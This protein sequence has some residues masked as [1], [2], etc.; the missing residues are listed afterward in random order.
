MK[1]ILYPLLHKKLNFVLTLFFIFYTLVSYSQTQWNADAVGG[2]SDWNTASNWTNGVPSTSVSVTIFSCTTCPTIS[3]ANQTSGYLQVFDG[4]KL[5]ID[6]GGSLTIET[7]G[8]SAMKIWNNA[9]VTI[10]SDAELT[11]QNFYGEGISIYGSL[12]NSGFLEIDGGH[13]GIYTLESGNISN[14]SSGEINITGDFINYGIFTNSDISNDGKIIIDKA[15]QAGLY[16]Q[17]G[18]VTNN[19][20][21]T[22]SNTGVNAIFQKNKIVNAGQIN[23]IDAL[24]GLYSLSANFENTENGFLNISANSFLNKGF[25]ANNG[26]FTNHGF[27]N[28][29]NAQNTAINTSNTL[30]FDNHGEITIEYNGLYGVLNTGNSNFI[31]HPCARIYSSDKIVNW[32]NF[33]NNGLLIIQTSET[34]NIDSNNGVIYNLDGGSVS[35]ANGNI[36]LTD[37]NRHAW[38]GCKNTAWTEAENWAFGNIPMFT[39]PNH[40]EE[41][42]IPDVSMTT[43]NSPIVSNIVPS[44]AGVTMME[45][46]KLTVANGGKLSCI[47]D[48]PPEGFFKMEPNTELNIALSGELLAHE[49]RLDGE[50]T[51]GGKIQITQIINGGGN[52][53]NKGNL[54]NFGTIKGGTAGNNGSLV[55][56][57]G[58]ME[59]EGTIDIPVA[60]FGGLSNT[61]QL[62]NNNVITIMG[63]LGVGGTLFNSNGGTFQ[64][65]GQIT[66]T[67]W[68]RNIGNSTFLNT[69][70]INIYFEGTA[71]N[72]NSSTFSNSGN[73]NI[74]KGKILNENA[75]FDNSG[76]LDLATPQFG[77]ENKGNFLN[78]GNIGI[79]A[80]ELVGIVNEVNATFNNSP[81]GFISV[82]DPGLEGIANQFI[83]SNAGT[84]ELDE[85]P[86]T[87]FFVGTLGQ[88]TNLASG[89]IDITNGLNGIFLDG[90][91]NNYGQLNIG[92]SANRGMYIRDGVFQNYTGGNTTIENVGIYGI[93]LFGDMTNT[94]MLKIDG[95]PSRGILIEPSG[96]LENNTNGQLDILNSSNIHSIGIANFSDR[97]NANTGV[98]NISNLEGIGFA[99][100]GMFTNRIVGEITTTNTG[101]DGIETWGTFENRGDILIATAGVNGFENQGLTTNF[102]S[103]RIFTTS[104]G[105]EGFLNWFPDG[106]VDNYGHIEVNGAQSNGL[107]NIGDAF[108]N[109]TEATI[110]VKGASMN[111]LL[112]TVPFYNSGTVTIEN[113]GTNAIMN[114]SSGII[115]NH[116]CA[117]VVVQNRI[118]NKNTF[119]NEGL[120]R[121][122]FSGTNI[123]SGEI[124][125]TGIIEDFNNSF[126]GVL[127]DNQQII[128]QPISG[129]YNEPIYDALDIATIPPGYTIGST[130]Y[131]DSG[132]TVPAG[133]YLGFPGGTYE[134]IFIPSV[135]LG[136]GT[137][138]LYFEVED[139]LHPEICTKV[140]AIKVVIISPTV[141]LFS[142]NNIE[143]EITFGNYPNPF[144]NETEVVFTLPRDAKAKVVVYDMKGTEVEILYKGE[145]KKEAQN[146]FTFDASDLPAGFYVAKIFSTNGRTAAIKMIKVE[147]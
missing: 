74:S 71:I 28:I 143:E 18:T 77:I 98:I 146:K 140:I 32:A 70:Q 106:F 58:M 130:W 73:L 38:L 63:S 2:T 101:V 31:N 79:V 104:S 135:S 141:V 19:N 97:F 45:N 30:T 78:S 125:N 142:S 37:S 121:T 147:D 24:T 144:D 69:E 67:G 126:D 115:N 86:G 16:Q 128:V 137:H 133:S 44:I 43:G 72:N 29:N 14:Y 80:P 23:I 139:D 82:S 11:V 127:V 53:Q 122:D 57:S 3:S 93:H 55:S 5:T 49:F 34:S 56:N 13:T 88:L 42:I 110:I 26:I 40:K 138:T 33:T 81:T 136:V 54:Q 7:P 109:F 47:F 132:L 8:S 9:N 6:S 39:P 50:I 66:L 113:A 36:P 119:N 90:T 10:N 107:K 21:I 83:F 96:K 84:I 4:G 41:A 108:R 15:I 103:G 87:P 64:N 35:V 52:L 102:E 100:G 59:N 76:I 123:N 99:N 105:N 117:E 118:N 75:T 116:P 60:L 92:S 61:G 85:G 1:T 48:V 95:F 134:N 25:F 94:G 129:L 20:E 46:A 68:M 91:V 17:N 22:I 120:L 62:T 89:T 27:I 12:N 114:E 51:N 111:G 124:I 145:V 65:S 131:N 112:N